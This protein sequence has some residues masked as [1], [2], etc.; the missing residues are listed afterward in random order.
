MNRTRKTDAP[1]FDDILAGL[2]GSA[3]PNAAPTLRPAGLRAGSG[4]VRGRA[5]AQAAQ[6][7]PAATID[8]SWL[9][10]AQARA[11]AAQAAR[12]TEAAA[13]EPARA[14]DA[15]PSSAGF[16]AAFDDAEETPRDDG[17]A[18]GGAT[19]APTSGRGPAA[20]RRAPDPVRAMRRLIA[21]FAATLGRRGGLAKAKPE[22]APIAPLDED[23]A[24]ARELGLSSD[25]AIGDLRRIRRDFAK[26]NHPDRF[27]PPQRTQ[28]A[29]RMTIANM[30]I[31]QQMKGRAP[32]PK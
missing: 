31:D 12:M 5:E 23:A 3:S 6:D 19:K 9:A 24:I 21:A 17:P 16:R 8:T 25:L 7:K 11:R 15:P 20:P 32:R 26:K 10:S 29:R 14:T 30:L 2:G 18:Q 13:Q 22:P 27:A 1:A 4:P 28:A